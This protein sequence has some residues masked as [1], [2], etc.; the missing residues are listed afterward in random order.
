MKVISDALTTHIN[1][2][3]TT[4]AT[5]WRI[6]RLDGTVFTFTD[7]DQDLVVDGETYSADTGFTRS[8]VDG[9]ITLAAPNLQVVGFVDAINQQDLQN[10]LWDYSQINI[11]LVNWSSPGDGI[12]KLRKGWLGEVTLDDSGEFQAELRGLAQVLGNNVGE[13]FSPECRAQLFDDR[14]KVNIASFTDTGAAGTDSTRSVFYHTTLTQSDG[15]YDGGVITMTSGANN[16]VRREIIS[17]SGGALALFLPMP[18]DITVG[19][20]FSIVPGCDK[21]STTCFNKFNNIINF[22]GEPFIPGADALLDYPVPGST[23]QTQ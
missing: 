11:F 4:L 5:C 13:L 1:Q 23:Q 22:R 15:Y 20:T 12:V 3:A 21:K 6:E 8:A 14:C 7:H 17:W 2:D 10:G 18:H 19:D 9:D 16:G